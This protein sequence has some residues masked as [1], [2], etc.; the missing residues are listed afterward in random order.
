MPRQLCRSVQAIRCR[1]AFLSPSC[2]SPSRR[3]CRRPGQPR[4]S[5]AAASRPRTGSS[6]TRWSSTY[7]WNRELPALEPGDLRLAAGLPRSGPLQAARRHLLLHRQPRRAGRPLLRQPVRR[8]RDDDAVRRRRDARLR[9]VPGQP[10]GRGRPEARRSLP[11]HQRPH[12][13]RPRRSRATSATAFGPHEEGLEVALEW[14]P[15]EGPDRKATLRKRVVTIPTGRADQ[16]LRGRRPQGRLHR[17][18]QLRRAVGRG[19]RRVVHRACATPAP[20][21]WCSTCATTAAGWSAS[22]STSPA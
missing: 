14:R 7:Y 6:A 2:A 10:G 13:R 18:P 5:R 4:R 9:G 12:G 21:S 16:A 19:A 1:N 11:D 8:A 15:L 20:P 22:P 17:V 3:S